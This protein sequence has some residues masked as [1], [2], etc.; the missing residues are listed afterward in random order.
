MGFRLVLMQGPDG[1]QRMA[2][3]P[4]GAKLPGEEGFEGAEGGIL[5][6]G[7][8]DGERETERA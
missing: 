8:D 2:L 7:G 5:G 3:V 4:P 6:E 1:S